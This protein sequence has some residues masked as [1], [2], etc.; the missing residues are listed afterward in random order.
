MRAFVDRMFEDDERQLKQA[1][2]QHTSKEV[3]GGGKY[4]A[5]VYKVIKQKRESYSSRDR[6]KFDRSL[7]AAATKLDRKK[8]A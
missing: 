5:S 3:A 1:S 6:A 4:D 8:A 7:K 2:I